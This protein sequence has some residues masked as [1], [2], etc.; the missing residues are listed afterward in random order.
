[1]PL[2]YRVQ[3]V[4]PYSHFYFAVIGMHRY[5]TASRYKIVP[6]LQIIIVPMDSLKSA[7]RVA[8][9]QMAYVQP[10]YKEVVMITK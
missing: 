2:M 10:L 7:V 8:P 1:M 9:S 3:P 4:H 5:K 6:E